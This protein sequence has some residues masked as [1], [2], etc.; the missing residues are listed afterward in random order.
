[1][2]THARWLFGI[3]GAVNLVVGLTLLFAPRAAAQFAS[4]DPAPG[5]NLVLV[6][7][8]GTMIALFGYGYLRIAAEPMRYRPLIHIGALG[9]LLAFACAAVPC[10]QGQIGPR[11]LTVL[12]PD[13]AFAA[14]FLHYLWRTAG[15]A[16]ASA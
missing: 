6:D 10:L 5:T 14:L 11:L 15:A 4:L 7:F 2:K 9:K 3:A 12:A 13:I 1:L 16:K 8:A